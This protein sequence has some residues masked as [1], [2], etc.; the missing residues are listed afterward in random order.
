M[1]H[2][3]KNTLL[4]LV[5]LILLISN[6]NCGPSAADKSAAG[7]KEL[8]EENKKYEAKIKKAEAD[9][10]KAKSNDIF[11]S[12]SLVKNKLSKLKVTND[13]FKKVR[14]YENYY[15][16]N[17][18]NFVHIYLVENNLKQIRGRF[19]ILYTSEDWLFIKSYSFLCDGKVY[20]YV[21]EH[22]VERDNSGGAIFEYSDEHFSQEL[23]TITYAII[24][25]KVCKLRCTGDQYYKDRLISKKEKALLN[26]MYEI[27]N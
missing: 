27:L 21:P 23:K 6:I 14:Y 7:L 16:S 2:N 4:I 12:H 24:N 9:L 20:N 13:E 3:K 15:N 25:S 10:E 17:Y 11:V 22:K 8:Q 1:I 18:S 5:W 26:E 19:K